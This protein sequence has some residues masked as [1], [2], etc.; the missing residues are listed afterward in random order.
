MANG[1]AFADVSVAGIYGAGGG[2]IS[3]ALPGLN[4]YSLL[5][6]MGQ[7]IVILSIRCLRLSNM[8]SVS[9]YGIAAFAASA[10]AL[11]VEKRAGC[12]SYSMFIVQLTELY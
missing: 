1:V 11:A 8:V 5:R 6:F 2:S 12:S 4:K 9:V 10:C 7:V 3:Q